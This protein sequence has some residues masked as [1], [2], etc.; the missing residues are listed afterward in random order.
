MPMRHFRIFGLLICIAPVSLGCSDSK[1][2]ELSATKT[3]AK[4]EESAPQS[5]TPRVSRE[6]DWFEDVTAQTGI[7]ATYRSGQEAKLYTILETVGGGVAIF[8]FDQDG[9]MDLFFPGGGVIS[10]NPATVTGK[11]SMLYR[12]D[13]DWHF[14][15]VT[16]ETGLDQLG[17]YSHGCAVNDFNR[18]GWPDLFMTCYGQ[19]R[20]Y[21][22]D[23]GQSFSDVTSESGLTF[24]NWSTAVTWGDVNRDGWPDLYIAGYVDWNLD[25]EEKCKA[26]EN[27]IRDVCP[28]QKY[29]AARDRLFLNREGQSFE[30]VT[31][32]AQLSTE[33]KGLGVLAADLNRDGWL[34]FYVANDG[35][36]NQLYLGGPEFP[37]REVGEASGTAFNEFGA[38]EGSM[39][40]DFSD[41]NG[42]GR[43]DLFVTNFEME[44]NSL[45][46]HVEGHAF[47]HG[48]VAARLGGQ[49]RT[50]VGFGTGFA[51]F[52]GDGWKD[53]F[54]INGNVFY[55]RGIAP[56]RQPPFLLR[57]HQGQFFQN[58]TDNAGPW[59]SLPH[60]GR[61]AAVGDLDNNGA[62]DLVI[63]HQDEPATILRNQ[64]TP[65]NWVRLR[66]KGTRCDPFAVGASVR[67]K[68]EGRTLTRFVR[69]GAGYLSQF[70]RR[71]VL[72][73]S[74]DQSTVEVTVQWPGGQEETFANLKVRK[75]NDLIEGTH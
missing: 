64:K 12:N 14:T 56:F 25:P 62:P 70:D 69:G 20:L 18:D 4:T 10:K 72:P 24:S 9:D 6:S 43:G 11:P 21:R 36:A 35:V 13:G 27:H 8:D 57:N 61:G 34:D 29:A 5:N 53:L 26:G 75:T 50:F 60:P 54:V 33:G 39:G 52:D 7:E 46:H 23:K 37:F 49:S 59:W 2:S 19:S 66:L 67:L 47:V 16:K 74:E 58:E 42:D 22:N 44:D 55:H 51:D 71:I 32:Q 1:T 31:E 65:S 38:P 15:D 45:Y 63:V 73:V 68:D 30:D 28:P 17:D 48:T 40:L 41:F 3:D